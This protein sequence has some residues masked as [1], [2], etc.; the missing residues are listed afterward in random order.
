MRAPATHIGDI[1]EIPTRD[2]LSAAQSLFKTIQRKDTYLNILN[3]AIKKR[4]EGP[5]PSDDASY[6]EK[7]L[8]SLSRKNND[9]FSVED[10]RFIIL[11]EIGL[12]IYIPKAICVLSQ[13]ILAEGDFYEGDLLSSVLQV[14]TSFWQDH[15][16]LR[17]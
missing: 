7:T 8:Y 4:W 16:E 13:N 6:V 12:D 3:Q 5:I 15:E 14:P 17:C 9:D 11:Q 10:L 1:F 2:A